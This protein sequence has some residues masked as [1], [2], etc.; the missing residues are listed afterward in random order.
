VSTL[1]NFSESLQQPRFRGGKTKKETLLCADRCCR[2]I[3]KG[4]NMVNK[5]GERVK[6]L[7][8]IVYEVPSTDLL[9]FRQKYLQ[10]TLL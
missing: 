2:E 1:R 6:K 4:E 5:P 10:S 8:N 9:K 7:S 3:D